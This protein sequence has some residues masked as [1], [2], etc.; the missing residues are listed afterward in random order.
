MGKVVFYGAIS[1]DGYLADSNDNLQWL[2]DTDL[3]GVSTY[4]SFAEKVATV[5]MGRI[6]YDEVLKLLQEESLYPNK[7][8]IVFSRTRTGEIHEGYFTSEDPVKVIGDLKNQVKDYIW[9]VGGGNLLTQLMKADLLDEYLIQIA[10]V[11]LG[12]GKR[13]FPTGNYQQRLT[14]VAT[15]QM[16][17]LVELHYR[18]KMT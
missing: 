6:T 15:T 11:L 3:A 8:K 16:G 4:E 10:P 13:L 1:L 2:F 17:E 18:K 7:Q 5:V 12:S 14:F 9:I